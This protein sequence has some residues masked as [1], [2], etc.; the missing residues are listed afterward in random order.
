[1]LKKF[2]PNE[3]VKSVLEISP[4]KL[5]E[6]GI[7][8]VITDLDNTLVE[9]DRP[10]ATPELVEWFKDIKEQGIAVTIV[11][12][13]QEKRVKDFADPLGI[14]FIF[15][16]RKP[17]IRAFNRAIREMNLQ[18]DEVVVIGDQLLTDVLGGN[19]CGLHT[20]LVVPVAQTDGF[21]TKFNRFVERKILTWMKRRGMLYWED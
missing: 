11:S 4:S 10:N 5:K 6:I 14:P 1:M 15:E 17:M 21:F 16:A 9:W 2:L 19:R 3:H 18:K 8:G 13:N 7:K 12:N 20:I